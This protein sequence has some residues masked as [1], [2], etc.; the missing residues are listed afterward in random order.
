MKLL[1]FIDP[2]WA[3]GTIFTPLTKHLTARGWQ[4]DVLSWYVGYR[5]DEMQMMASN[6]DRIVTVASG[7]KVLLHDYQIPPSKIIVSNYSDYDITKAQQE[8]LP[9]VFNEV[10]GYFVPS[11]NLLSIS[12][13]MGITRIPQVLPIGLEMKRYEG[14]VP[15]SLK[16]VG[17]GTAYARKNH[18]GV[19]FK[20]GALAEKCA[21]AAGLEFKAATSYN[22]LAVP[23]YW[24]TVDCLL[25]SALYETAP[26]PQLEAAAS[27][28][29]VL[30]SAV[31]NTAELA[32]DDICTILPSNEADFEEVAVEMLRRLAMEGEWFQK[33]CAKAREGVSRYDWANVI[34]QWMKFFQSC[35]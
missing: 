3:F 5:L 34:G 6:Y 23:A 9:P 31:G 8:G 32:C 21:K 17:Y 10:A 27:G 25:A 26:I 19:E 28:R 7:L 12:L 16:V 2:N 30:T 24:Q 15:Q 1:F 22:Y 14:V 29:L 20:R 11:H 33:R 4:A 35:Q 13:A 18:F